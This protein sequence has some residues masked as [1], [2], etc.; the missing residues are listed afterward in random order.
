[1]VAAVVLVDVR[2]ATELRHHHDQCRIEHASIGQV[3]HQ[4]REPLVELG[5]LLE[6]EVEVLVVGVVVRVIQL[7]ER[8]P[9]LEQPAGRQ[10]PLPERLTP[11]ELLH[12]GRLFRDVKDVAA[13]HQL[14]RPLVAVGIRFGL[15]RATSLG[16]T[17]VGR[18][19]QPVPQLVGG[20]A[21][22]LGTLG[23]G[24][25]LAVGADAGVTGSEVGRIVATTTTT[26]TDVAGHRIARVMQRPGTHRAQS[27]QA[28]ARH[29]LPTVLHVVVPLAVVTVLGVDPADDRQLVHVLG[30]QR[31]Q[32]REMNA[33][34]RGGDRPERA[35]RVGL[36]LGIPTLQLA[37]SARHVD[38]DDPLLGLLELLGRRKTGH[39]AQATGHAAG[40]PAQELPSSHRVLVTS[41]GSFASHQYS[42]IFDD[43]RPGQVILLANNARC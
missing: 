11:V 23:I 16:E 30:S 2:R 27:R 38:A 39:H 41:A 29:P 37:Q 42:P 1:M 43:N 20:F 4:C 35:T 40:N 9:V 17:I 5:H 36:G 33:G 12:L 32:F 18:A 7:D 3:T 22:F 10:A 24:R 21:E 34:D 28:H 13:F 14:Q 6:V 26:N 8:G 19:T 15:G 31:E 25:R